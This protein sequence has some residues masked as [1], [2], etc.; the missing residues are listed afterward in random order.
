MVTVTVINLNIEGFFI[1]ANNADVPV[2]SLHQTKIT[3]EFVTTIYF[4]VL[5]I[6]C[7]EGKK[8]NILSLVEATLLCPNINFHISFFMLLYL[9]E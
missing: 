7:I 4:T 5:L 6:C 9:V 3:L 1:M 2:K 8:Q